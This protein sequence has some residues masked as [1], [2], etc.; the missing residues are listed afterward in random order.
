MAFQCRYSKR[1]AYKV[2][3]EVSRLNLMHERGPW[4]EALV[5]EFGARVL[6]SRKLLQN[7]PPRLLGKK[8]LVSAASLASIT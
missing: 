3:A 7:L 6:I 2:E 5:H 8:L 1:W 4:R